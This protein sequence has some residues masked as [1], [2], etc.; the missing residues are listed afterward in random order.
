MDI[1]FIETIETSVF[2]CRKMID[3]STKFECCAN[4]M[5]LKDFHCCT[6]NFT[7]ATS[8]TDSVECESV[9]DVTTDIGEA[10]RIFDILCR[11]TVHPCH[12]KEVVCD[13][14]L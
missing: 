12:L 6:Y 10:E 2:Y 4:M 8:R 7:V 13:L 5:P 1:N 9:Q 11:N 3:N 14:I